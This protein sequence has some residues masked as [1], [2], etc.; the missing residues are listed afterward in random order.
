M[1][2]K[3]VTLKSWSEVTHGRRK[4]YHLI[5]CVWFPIKCS[6]VT[7]SVRCIVFDDIRLVTIQWPW[8]PGYESLKVIGANTDRLAT[9]DFLLTFHCNHGSISYT[10][11]EIY[12]DFSRKLQQQQIPTHPLYFASLLKGFPLEFGYWRWGSKPRMIVL[13]GRQRNLTISSAVWIECTNVTDGQTHKRTPDHEK[14]RA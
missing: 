2:R 7:L 14:D 12:G 8:N 9:C 4:W 10:V 13:P 3:L 6:I 1:S 5:D 11:S